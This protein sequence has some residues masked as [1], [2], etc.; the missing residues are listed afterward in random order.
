[1]AILFDIQLILYTAESRMAEV[2]TRVVTITIIFKL[3]LITA[4]NHVII[5]FSKYS[6]FL[7]N[8]KYSKIL[9]NCLPLRSN[10]RDFLII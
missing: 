6:S 8:K 5:I 3:R 1:M 7:I 10:S 9:K 4:E 2:L